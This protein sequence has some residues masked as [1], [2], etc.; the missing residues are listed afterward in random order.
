MLYLLLTFTIISITTAASPDSH[1]NKKKQVP[2]QQQ[3]GDASVGQIAV[4]EALEGAEQGG[5]P[6]E[7]ATESTSIEVKKEVQRVDAS[8]YLPD[9]L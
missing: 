1:N 4:D 5:I 9:L 8:Q 2:I 6:S 7:G 3:K